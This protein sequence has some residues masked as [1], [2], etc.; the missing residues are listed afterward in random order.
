MAGREKHISLVSGGLDSAVALKDAADKG[1]VAVAL[2]FDYGQRALER[3]KR[4]AQAMAARLAGRFEIV[5]MRWLGGITG[6][7]I[8]DK[9]AKLPALDAGAL[10][11]K[12][13]TMKSA[14]AVWVPNRNAC[15]VSIGAAWAEALGCEAVVAGFN[16]EEG[17]TFPDNSAAFVSAMNA[18]LKISTGGKVRLHCPLIRMDKAR[19]V[20]HGVA[21]GAPLGEIWS[22]YDGGRKFCW[23][24]ESCARLRRAL[25]SNGRL[26]WFM[27]VNRHAGK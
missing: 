14:R 20:R 11:D 22:C 8:V 5:D 19:I 6:A 15:M 16:R 23:R 4:A 10:C 7:A 13:A 24:C 26:D 18:L 3:E 9:R 25:E 1:G 17:E 2:F 12:A 27:R 21:I